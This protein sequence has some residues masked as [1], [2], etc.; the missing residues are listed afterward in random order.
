MF[1]FQGIQNLD[2]GK[3]IETSC[4]SL[5]IEDTPD[6]FEQLDAENPDM[7]NIYERIPGGNVYKLYIGNFESH[8]SENFKIFNKLREASPDDLVEIYISS[9]GGSFYEIL[10]FYNCI[11]PKFSNIITFLNRG[12]SAGSLMFLIGEERVVYEHSDFMVHSYSSVMSG[13]RQD[14]LDQTLHQD[15]MITN[16]FNKMYKPYFTKK[17]LKK[18]NKGQDFWLNSDEMLKRGIATG[19][20]KDTGEYVVNEKIE[21]D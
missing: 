18:I 3:T 6:K 11:K 7:Q 1:E 20:I 14:M 2:D 9:D 5:Y 12:Y 15:K 16:F 13:K 17:E 19:I 8:Q 10:D 21:K 4:H